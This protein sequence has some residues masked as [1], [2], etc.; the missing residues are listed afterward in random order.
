MDAS[1]TFFAG[2]FEVE[3]DKVR[4]SADH[5]HA[6]YEYQSTSVESKDGKIKVTPTTDCFEFQ[7]DR[8]VPKLGIMLVGL[9]GNNGTTFTAGIIANRKNISWQTK[10]REIK[11]NYQIKANYLGSLTQSQICFWQ[12][13]QTMV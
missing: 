2:A 11:A 3:S 9:G 4:Y 7:T 6:E 12:R 10:E 1:D 5:I 13:M 8:K